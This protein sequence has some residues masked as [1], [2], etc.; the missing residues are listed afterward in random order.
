[1]DKEQ[2]VLEKLS[3]HL[4]AFEMLEKKAEK[5]KIQ[6]LRDSIGEAQN[7]SVLTDDEISLVLAYRAHQT[8]IDQKKKQADVANIGGLGNHASYASFERT[9]KATLSNFIKVMRGLGRIN[10]LEGLLKR[11]ISAKLAELESGSGRKNKR[12][13]KDKFFE[14][15]DNLL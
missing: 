15:T 14:D 13:I 1:M 12:R 2:S 6:E 4:T 10:E 8:R 11:D 9:G 5:N 7:F 3:R